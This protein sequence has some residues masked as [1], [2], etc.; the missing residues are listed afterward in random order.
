MANSFPVRPNTPYLFVS[1]SHADSNQVLP[2]LKLLEEQGVHYWYD[3]SIRSGSDW[4]NE[5]ALAIQESI[6]FL[7]FISEHYLNSRHCLNELNFSIGS[8]KGILPI[9]LKQMTLPPGLQL[10]I[11]SIQ[12]L[13]RQPEDMQKYQK[14]LI[15]DA[16]QLAGTL[17]SKTA[18][19][20]LENQTHDVRWASDF[21]NTDLTKIEE[22]ENAATVTTL[23]LEPFRSLSSSDEGSFLAEGMTEDLTMFLSRNPDI[24]VVNVEK[25]VSQDTQKTSDLVSKHQA[26]YIFSGSVSLVTGK[27]Q[28]RA[29]LIDAITKITVWTEQF[30]REVEDIF[31]VQGDLIRALADIIGPAI[32]HSEGQRMA[33]QNA[34][35]LRSWE[36][37]HRAIYEQFNGFSRETSQE[38]ERL[39]RRAI[40]I[41]PSYALASST[42]ALVLANRVMQCL[43][44][45]LENE[46][47]A[48]ALELSE[49]ATM[50]DPRDP[51]I[52][53][54]SSVVAVAAGD[55]DMALRYSR[56]SLEYDTSVGAVGFLGLIL[57]MR[58]DFDEGIEL[59]EREIERAPDSNRLYLSLSNIG[60]A[61]IGKNEFSIAEQYLLDAMALH[62]QYH[63][64]LTELS[65][66]QAML[67]RES[68]ARRSIE[69]LKKMEPDI[70][71]E[72]I[73][74][75][76]QWQ[77]DSFIEHLQRIWQ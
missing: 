13:I 77:G 46:L 66:C 25:N 58:G 21:S 39:A 26:H 28:M 45:A 4:Q 31:E 15:S 54:G 5:I 2:D 76:L 62:P 3:D 60:M 38:A 64:N 49:R 73:C 42:L 10:S 52:L 7:C 37:T 75:Q 30:R 9:Y 41:D 55:I 63:M 47:L 69:K 29:K 16:S 22:A 1:Y 8:Q 18:E 19:S 27:L 50:L 48:E 14:R 65:V 24:Q 70:T 51:R 35:D 11:G 74:Q 67:D 57:I 72:T 53:T 44:G 20:T 12:G 56:K 61:Y 23:L 71:L 59:T 40:E 33:R 17:I 32:W 34:N 36:L 43:A 68:D 6:G